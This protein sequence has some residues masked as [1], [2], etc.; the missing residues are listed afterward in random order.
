MFRVFLRSVDYLALDILLLSGFKSCSGSEDEL[1]E[2]SLTNKIFKM[3]LEGTTLNNVVPPAVMVGIILYAS[4]RAG[5][6][7]SGFGH[8]TQ[9]WP[10]MTRKIWSI[11]RFNG[12]K[13]H[14]SLKTQSWLCEGFKFTSSWA[15]C[16]RLY[17]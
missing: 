4:G 12:V 10:S 9:G 17:P 16:P 15:S 5:S 13:S 8:F 1:S 3:L 2:V 7:W 11:G 14:P 6:Y